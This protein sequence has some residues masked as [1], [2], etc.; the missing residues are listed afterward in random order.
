MKCQADW[1]EMSRLNSYRPII[2]EMTQSQINEFKNY[3]KEKIGTMIKI[4]NIENKTMEDD[5]YKLCNYCKS[6][7]KNMNNYKIIISNEIQEVGK[8]NDDYIIDKVINPIY[9]DD[10]KEENKIE[11]DVIIYRDSSNNRIS[12]IYHN[13]IFSILF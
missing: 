11:Y 8:N 10:V 5:Y 13:S 4:E 7:Y 6:L 3:N 2:E 1:G 12:R 9:Y